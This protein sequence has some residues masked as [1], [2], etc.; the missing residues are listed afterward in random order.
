MGAGR[1]KSGIDLHPF[2]GPDDKVLL[3]RVKNGKVSSGRP[4]E[5]DWKASVYVLARTNVQDL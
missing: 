4:D 3:C 2:T 5:P 1:L